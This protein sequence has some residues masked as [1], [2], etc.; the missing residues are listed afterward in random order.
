[1]AEEV[2]TVEAL[3]EVLDG[4]TFL[5]NEHGTTE[6]L[7]KEIEA[8]LLT[9]TPPNEAA[10]M[11]IGGH[12]VEPF[13]LYQNA[14]YIAYGIIADAYEGDWSLATEQWRTSAEQW[15]AAYLNDISDLPIAT[16]P[17]P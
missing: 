3:M 13:D 14:L 1:M 6:D 16:P 15:T 9:K 8:H 10:M 17:A 7:A 11:T 12:L 2:I 4:V 5:S